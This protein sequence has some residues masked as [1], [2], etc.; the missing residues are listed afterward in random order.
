MW[1]FEDLN[2]A[3]TGLKEEMLRLKIK[4]KQTKLGKNRTIDGLEECSKQ[5][6]EV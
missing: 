4:I 6:S 3:V 2:T 1:C 5:Q